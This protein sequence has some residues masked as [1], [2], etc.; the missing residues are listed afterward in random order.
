MYNRDQSGGFSLRIRPL[1]EL[2]DMYHTSEAT[3]L[4]DKVYALLG[5]SSDGPG[6]FWIWPDYT[7]ARKNL[8]KLLVRLLITGD[9]VA[10]GTWDG[11][12]IAVILAEVLIVGEVSAI[13]GSR[14]E[15]DRQQIGVLLRGAT[16]VIL[17]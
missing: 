1:G 10:V 2:P 13:M 14:T 12:E 8:L 7:I 5:M 3:N 15:Y 17:M 16:A 4:R 6:S 9:E 11:E